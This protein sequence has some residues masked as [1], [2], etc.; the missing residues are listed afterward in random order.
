LTLSVFFTAFTPLQTD[1]LNNPF[2][3]GQTQRK[4]GTQSYKAKVFSMKAM[5]VG[6]PKAGGQ[7]NDI[8]S[9]AALLPRDYLLTKAKPPKGGDAK[10]RD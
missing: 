9:P 5:P 10:P 2:V 3:P 1:E 6:P 7:R 8:V 4:P